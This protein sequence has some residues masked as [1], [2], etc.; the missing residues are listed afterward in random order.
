LIE[1]VGADLRDYVDV[2]RDT[3]MALILAGYSH[4]RKRGGLVHHATGARRSR[5]SDIPGSAAIR[6]KTVERSHD[7]C[8][9][10]ET[11]NRHWARRPSDH[12]PKRAR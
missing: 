12:G 2:R 8:A 10:I 7:H 1:N 3:T 6:G 4:R 5:S 11:Q 9:A